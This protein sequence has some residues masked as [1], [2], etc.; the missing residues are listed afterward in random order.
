MV[1]VFIN[2]QQNNKKETISK[3]NYDACGKHHLT[4]ISTNKREVLA[5]SFIAVAQDVTIWAFWATPCNDTTWFWKVQQF[6]PSNHYRTALQNTQTEIN[7]SDVQ[8]AQ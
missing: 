2:N 8:T 5:N 1:T 7:P 4:Q 6:L 3:N